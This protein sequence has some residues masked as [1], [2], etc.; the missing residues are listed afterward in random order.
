MKRNA[1]LNIIVIIA[2]LSS[3]A[4]DNNQQNGVLIKGTIPKKGSTVNETDSFHLDDVAKVLLFSPP[5]AHNGVIFE[6]VDMQE[7]QFE[8]GANIGT[9]AALIFLTS[10]YEYVGNL[11]INDLNLLPLGNLSNGEN[12]VIDLSTL[13]MVGNH[14]IPSHDPFGNEIIISEAALQGF[15]DVDAYFESLAKNMDTD[16]NG[17]MDFI[18]HEEVFVTTR[19]Y[20]DMGHYGINSTPPNL[21]DSSTYNVN[22]QLQVIGGYNLNIIDTN[23]ALSGPAGDPYSDISL[24]WFHLNGGSESGTTTLFARP[25]FAPFKAGVYT[26][27]INGAELHTFEY[28]NIDAKYNLFI[29]SPTLTVNGANQITSVSLDYKLPNGSP[30]DPNMVISNVMIQFTDTNFNQFFSTPRLTAS[31]GFYNYTLSNPAELSQLSKVT[32][33]YDDLLGNPYLATWN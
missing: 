18:G 1:W 11:T 30:I 2:I 32:I 8:V 3:C 27:A 12:T 4:P 10:N 22:Y 19:F 14:V 20:I 26:L 9:A 28:S 24:F 21:Y 6:V 17:I 13:T 31:E 33:A 16:N 29:V 15:R 7:G 23:I 5:S 25:S